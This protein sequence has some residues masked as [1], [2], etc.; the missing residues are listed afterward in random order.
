MSKIK[1][2][3]SLTKDAIRLTI[4]LSEKLGIPQSNVLEIAIRKLAEQENISLDDK[5]SQ[6]KPN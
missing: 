1:T 5:A 4:R 6:E 3:Y 2:S